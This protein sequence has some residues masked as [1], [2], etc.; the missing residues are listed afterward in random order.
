MFGQN[1]I[2]KCTEESLVFQK[3]LRNIYTN[4]RTTG[5]LRSV[6]QQRIFNAGHA[7]SENL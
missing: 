3:Y 4:N 1:K 7:L 5:E 2:S 6:E